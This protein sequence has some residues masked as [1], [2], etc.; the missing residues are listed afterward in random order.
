MPCTH[1]QTRLGF[2]FYQEC[3]FALFSRYNSVINC[4]SFVKPTANHHSC[5]S[6][7]VTALQCALC[8]AFFTM[9]QGLTKSQNPQLILSWWSVDETNLNSHEKTA[10]RQHN[11]SFLFNLVATLIRLV[12]SLPFSALFSWST[13]RDKFVTSFMNSTR[14]YPSLVILEQG[15][16]EGLMSRHPLGSTNSPAIKPS[17]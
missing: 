3:L 17:S 10:T 6:V 9:Q 15:F 4:S 11:V 14:T 13:Q 8:F 2:L 7:I 1:W 16:V 12:C 5:S